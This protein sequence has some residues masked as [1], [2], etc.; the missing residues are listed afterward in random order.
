MNCENHPDRIASWY[1]NPWI[2]SGSVPVCDECKF[3]YEDLNL[4]EHLK[5][6]PISGGS[7]GQGES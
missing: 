6:R 1:R 5:L 7:Q 4:A 2:G 3:H